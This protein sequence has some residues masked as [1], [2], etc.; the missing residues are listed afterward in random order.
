MPLR[1]G[2][3]EQL[4]K[5]EL[6]NPLYLFEPKN[7]E[8][9]WKAEELVYEYLKMHYPIVVDFTF[10][11]ELTGWI[12]KKLNEEGEPQNY[13]PRCWF[14]NFLG[15]KHDFMAKDADGKVFFVEAKSPQF[16]WL[17]W[18]C[19]ADKEQYDWY[20]MLSRLIPF[21]IYAWIPEQKALYIHQVRD[22]K[23]PEMKILT[24]TKTGQQAYEIPMEEPMN[25]IRKVPSGEIQRVLDKLGW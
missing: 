17:Q 14:G 8:R 2:K 22:P 25:E 24:N 13:E 6:K 10:P 12:T 18:G 20:F 16:K 7:L 1:F 19:G 21:Y 5:H 4:S 3:P 15:S 23:N 11:K 9:G